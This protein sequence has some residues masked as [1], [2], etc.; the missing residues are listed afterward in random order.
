M[1]FSVAHVKTRNQLV[2]TSWRGG[3]LFKFD[4]SLAPL[5]LLF[6]HLPPVS[7]LKNP[8]SFSG[9]ATSTLI[10]SDAFSASLAA[11]STFGSRSG[12]IGVFRA[13]PLDGPVDLLLFALTSR[14]EPL[15]GAHARASERWR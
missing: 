3:H 8:F 6:A 9:S 4:F 12:S 7:Q 13:H 14:V 5:L 11:A 2:T 10:A 15:V 1:E